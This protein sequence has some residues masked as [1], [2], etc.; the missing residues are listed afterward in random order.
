MIEQ[1]KQYIST[2]R[3]FEPSAASL[4]L[5]VSGGLD[6]SV[7]VHLCV[8]AGL[9]VEIAHC[10]FQLRGEESLRDEQFVQELAA[11]CGLPFHVQRFNTADY[12][13][14]HKLSTQV[15]ARELRYE[16]LEALRAQQN[17][18]YIATA[19]HM[20]DN[21]ET[22][23]MNIS[24][25]TG[26]AGMHGILP[27]QGLLVRPL[28]FATRTEIAAYA[29]EQGITFTED[30][31]NATDKYTRNYFRHQ[32][33]P[34]LEAVYPEVVKNTGATIAR[35]REAETLYRQ[36]LELHRKKLLEQRGEEFFIPILKLK[37]AEPLGTILYELLKPFHISPAQAQQVLQLLNGEPGRWV[38]SHSHR[39]VRDRKWLIITPL[40]AAVS[41]HFMIEEGQEQVL[42]P[43]EAALQ[44]RIISAA[45]AALPA[46]PD[47]A[48]IDLAKLQFPL[49]LR[50][51]KQGDYFYPLGM[52]KKKKLSRFF[53]DQ[54]LSL[55]EKEKVW[56][57][58][59]AQRIVWVAGMRIDDRFKVTPSTRNIFQLQLKRGVQ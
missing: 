24:K 48:S 44:I 28:L 8:K 13:L 2:E 21:A 27:K 40:E 55:P 52:Q 41:A 18:T 39:V 25:G 20:Q 37:Q 36:A 30:S 26:M 53:I 47:I 56:V 12:A 9:R 23:W 4:L 19:H 6:S 5:A 54:K 34:K 11:Q 46:T 16:W 58:E 51:W 59:S 29:S 49:M 50:K 3:L 57:L 45:N 14:Q 43:G 17:L 15:A 10:N 35:L 32:I 38:A 33:L 22:L 7:L 31:S 42:L 1:F